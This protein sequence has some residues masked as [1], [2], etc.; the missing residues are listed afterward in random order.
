M[1]IGSI[2]SK[3]IV[4][5]GVAALACA[6][7]AILAASS[8]LAGGPQSAGAATQRYVVSLRG[9]A[10]S[11]SGSVPQ[12]SSGIAQTGSG[13]AESPAA[14]AQSDTTRVARIDSSIDSLE[15]RVGFS[16][17][18]RYHYAIQGFAA[19]LTARQLSELRADPAVAGVAPVLPVTPAELPAGPV[20]AGA[21][22]TASPTADA[23][24]NA[25][26]PATNAVP[27][28]QITPTGI[29][30]IHADGQLPSNLSSGMGSVNVA[31]LDTG[32]SDPDHQLNLAGGVDCSSGS[33]GHT[34][35]ND[36]RDVSSDGHG[37]HVAGIIGAA[38]DTSDV[39]GVAP[40]ARIWSVRVFGLDTHG[41]LTGSTATVICGIDWVAATRAAGQSDPIDVANMSLVSFTLKPS[42][43][44]QAAGDPE[45]AAICAATV[46]GATFV[47]AAGNEGRDAATD[48][49]A[50]YPEV[51]T[52]SALSDYDGKDG[53]LAR[54]TCP[55]NGPDD[56]FASFS[57]YG[58]AVD[59]LAPGSCITSLN[60]N[61]GNRVLSGTSMA[62]PHVTGA[63][64]RFLAAIPQL[65]RPGTEEIRTDV[66]ASASYD[67]NSASDPDGTPD[68]LLDVASLT[69]DPAN[70]AV[71]VAALPGRVNFANGVTTRPVTVGLTRV[72]L[73]AGSVDVGVDLTGA[74]AGVG[75]SFTGPTSLSGLDDAGILAT[76]QVTVAQD[77]PDGVITLQV[78]ATPSGGS[79][80]TAPL[81]LHVDRSPPVTANLTTNVI[82]GGTFG[83]TVPVR[84]AW[85]GHDN[86]SITGY[87]LQRQTTS[88]GTQTVG[89]PAKTTFSNRA[90]TPKVD[91]TFRVRA[92]DDAGNVGAWD[93]LAIRLG[94]RDSNQASIVYSTGDWR[95]VQHS[96]AS[97]GSVAE[98]T[99]KGAFAGLTFHGIGVAWVAPVGPHKGI[100]TVTLDSVKIT[101]NLHAS[102]AGSR[103]I[104]F[105]SGPL[106]D[107]THFM[108]VTVASGT[109]DLDAI[110]ILG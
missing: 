26:V 35:A 17:A 40:G 7:V 61:G 37:T 39:V 87:Q 20:P 77:V 109:V 6:T 58:P 97:G 51:I 19:D 9:M 70:Q 46:A 62:A 43:C 56:G 91:Y 49:P 45:H 22:P 60:K 27:V 89:L 75:A 64:A 96:T 2:R 66:R 34:T 25:A 67:W 13:P 71:A 8:V 108:T 47:A 55:G 93:S 12:G 44:P 24:A 82:Q 50:A 110:L 68:R 103:R 106:A 74:P 30:R 104:V 80:V 15:F 107:T 69:A 95:T 38:N 99:H 11:P 92:T 52:V 10:G 63:I 79:T 81:T 57:N 84:V 76:L 88:G 102:T 32:I 4:R 90:M 29:A 73:Y 72:G 54:P 85:T 100:A 42:A 28:Q 83:S 53:A 18:F 94:V 78:T 1:R 3:R 31:V 48:V 36:Y 86:G 101:I 14:V 98:A 23:S 105:S 65:Q 59:V 41:Q 33:P 16:V 5:A 21:G